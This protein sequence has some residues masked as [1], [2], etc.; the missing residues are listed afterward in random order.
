MGIG[1]VGFG[2][3][4]G[5]LAKFR[6]NEGSFPVRLF[7]CVLLFLAYGA[8]TSSVLAQAPAIL[9]RVST[10]YSF[11]DADGY[12]PY[13]RVILGSDSFLYGT[14][15]YGGSNGRGTVYKISPSGAL[16]TLGS[17][18]G[19]AWGGLVQGQNG[20]FYGTTAYGGGFGSV[21]KITPGGVTSIL[22]N[23]NNSNGAYPYGV[24]WQGIDGDFYGTTSKGG[25][26]DKGTIFKITP[27]GTLSTLYVFSQAGSGSPSR[28]LIQTADGNFYGTTIDGGSGGNGTV[29]KLTTGGAL[30]T[31]CSFTTG[32]GARPQA[33]VVLG[34]DGNFYGTTYA[35]GSND[36]GTVFK[37][38]PA[39]VLTTLCSFTGSNGKWPYAGLLRG[40]DGNFYGVT[41][42][43][44]SSDK[45]TVF[46]VTPN[47]VLTTIHSFTGSNGANPYATL[48]LG[49]DG[50]IYGTT[51][52]SGSTFNGN[53][54]V[55][56]V[57]PLFTKAYAQT[58]FSY[59]IVATNF[60]ASYAA[61]GLPAGLSINAQTGLISGTPTALGTYNA[62]ISATNVDGTGTASF[63][64]VVASAPPMPVIT[65]QLNATAAYGSPFNYQIVATSY[66][67]SYAVDGLPS[68]LVVDSQTGLISGTPTVSGPFTVTLRALNARGEGS[69]SLVIT[70]AIPPDAPAIT[71]GSITTATFGAPFQYQIEANNRPVGYGA[72]GLP[73]GLSVNT[74]TG[75]IG[76]TPTATGTFLVS[77]SA[78]N[79][80]G[81]GTADLEITVVP[82]S[83]P[84]FANGLSVTATQSAPFS[85]QLEASN[86]PTRYMASGLPSGLSLN[87]YTGLISGE[88]TV[89][90][91]FN[92]SISASN[93]SG[94]GTSSIA[95]S[96]VLPSAPTITS[97]VSA[98][99]ISGVTFSYQIAATHYP[100]S[101]AASGLPA[102]LG[103]DTTTGLISGTP[104]AAG[105]FNISLS[106]VNPGGTGTGALSLVVSLP[107][108]PTIIYPF[109]TLH[110]FT[111]I[112]GIPYSSLIQGRDGNFYGTTSY[113]GSYGKGGVF[114][115]S[116][117]GELTALC[118]FNGT[119]G[120]NPQTNLVEHANGNFYGT[121]SSG[122]A[123]NY[124]TV[125]QVTPNGTLTTLVSFNQAN[126]ASPDGSLVLGRDGSFY[127][128]TSGGGA[129]N[130]GTVYRITQAGVLTVLRSFSGGDGIA[131]VSGLTQGSD[132]NFYGVT[133]YGGSYNSGSIFKIA[134]GGTF[135]GL[136]SFTGNPGYHPHGKLVQGRDGNFY[137]TTAD[138]GI[139]GRGTTYK[140]TP[141]GTVTTL[142]SFVDPEG[143]GPYGGMIQARDG[144]FYGITIGGTNNSGTLYKMTPS[145]AVTTL[146]AFKGS[147]G[148]SPVGEMLEASD[149]N[150][151]GTTSTG[152]SAGK[153]AVYKLTASTL[154]ATQ[155]SAFSYQITATGNPTSY[156]ASG[157]PTGLTVDTTTGL[158]SGTP[159][160]SGTFSVVIRATNS[161]G[162]G[163]GV[164]TMEV[165]PGAP[166]IMGS[167]ELTAV[168][169]SPFISQI[170][171]TGS[172]SRYAASSLPPGLNVNTA[173]GVI[174]GTPTVTGNFSM[175]VSATNTGGT[176]LAKVG[177][178][179]QNTLFAFRT[180][181]G[182]PGDGSEDIHAPAGDGVPNLF[183]Y[184]FNMIGSGKGQATSLDIAN[185]QAVG[186]S[187]SAG[188]PSMD[189]D[190]SGK[191]SVVFVRRKAATSP[192]VNYVV[193]FCDDLS[194]NSWVINALATESVTDIDS[195][196][197]R[198]TVTDS[199][200]T[201]PKRFVRVRVVA[202]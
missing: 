160:I 86:Y 92:V 2:V 116:L 138:G 110:S 170:L 6:L 87:T 180:N 91:S 65:S 89:A 157:L 18:S 56:K 150:L 123:N 112:F 121:T 101:Y 55:F 194:T 102:G 67:T 76:G 104:T 109:S 107:S 17:L 161:G 14:T 49:G 108:A 132:G 80:G 197:E 66:P 172:P 135:T 46:R 15:M 190:T 19:D 20:D 173:S 37:V 5:D 40:D 159:L 165:A 70:I 57:V 36:C 195:T 38:T 29:F 149:G 75:V 64:I 7:Y 100:T 45:G 129:Y 114:K 83:P 16:T 122:G 201:A 24:L 145:G 152:G 202:P 10:V 3:K 171:A 77:L 62:T 199:L 147:D 200:N 22:F 84:E 33:G 131:P 8:L 79:T 130:K 106:A 9:N 133:F 191:L 12:S 117:T 82:P 25:A 176:A 96:V 183:K 140:M 72:S 53:G 52:Y 58:A 120:N 93:V 136:F 39:G 13:G 11:K 28:D 98:T 146:H 167:I 192:G 148:S 188:L 124:G 90:G 32:H 168:K 35:G 127:G 63:V 166:V 179:V 164:I 155:G 21:Y 184:A 118:S 105:T 126:G 178:T 97:S 74:Q 78:S 177:L 115:L 119:N 151:Y 47:G 99:A 27:T 143:S 69:A 54:T 81:T 111:G 156:S 85:Y 44:G 94:T 73:G 71:S 4:R 88:P 43:G 162:S 61:T 68:G 128:T 144:N 186:N 153:G 125:F 163:V 142:H 175:V 196:V 41:W 185:N 103:I 51:A 187:G 42:A 158:I 31:L 182:L 50:N 60:A 198:V 1:F 26:S 34:A 174:S 134:P 193:E 48:T 113:G 169:G 23:F 181:A 137:G 95:I 154:T 59:Q 141:S 189:V 139:S 30:T